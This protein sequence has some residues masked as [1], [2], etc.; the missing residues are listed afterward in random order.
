[1]VLACSSRLVATV[2]SFIPSMRLLSADF[3]NEMAFCGTSGE[4]GEVSGVSVRA[5][6][7]NEST[8]LGGTEPVNIYLD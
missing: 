4:R 1:M 3:F 8:M 5:G 2:S 7:T 6:Y